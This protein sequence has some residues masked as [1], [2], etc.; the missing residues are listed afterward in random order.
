MSFVPLYAAIEEGPV[1]LEEGL[2]DGLH[3]SPAGNRLLY[4]LLEPL[5]HERVGHMDDRFPNWR[6]MT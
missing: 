2:S 1:T 4:D 5:M 6:D 3:L